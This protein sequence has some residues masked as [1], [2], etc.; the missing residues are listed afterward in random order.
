MNSPCSTH[1][2]TGGPEFCLACLRLH[3]DRA[4]LLADVLQSRL[5]SLAAPA[6]ER[7]ARVVE[8]MNTGERSRSLDEAL[9]EYRVLVPR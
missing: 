3:A 1:G 9:R 2:T 8:A 7:L 5:D 4:T 6:A